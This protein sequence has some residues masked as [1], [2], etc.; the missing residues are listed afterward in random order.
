MQVF[1]RRFRDPIQVPRIRETC[2]RVS[3]IKENQVPRIREIGS[4]QVQTGYLT[5]SLKKLMYVQSNFSDIN[6]LNDFCVLVIQNVHNLEK[7]IFETSIISVRLPCTYIPLR[8]CAR[9]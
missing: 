2:H 4:L 5:F 7:N 6:V 8:C 9:L 3:R 1:L